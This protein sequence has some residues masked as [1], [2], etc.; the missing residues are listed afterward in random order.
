MSRNEW[1]TIAATWLFILYATASTHIL[2][3][4]L[5]GYINAAKPW[6]KRARKPGKTPALAR[7]QVKT[8][9]RRALAVFRFFT[10][11]TPFTHARLA[12]LHV[13]ALYEIRWHARPALAGVALGLSPLLLASLIIGDIDL[14]L[15]FRNVL[16]STITVGTVIYGGTLF[17]II[18]LASRK[19]RRLGANLTAIST[20]LHIATTCAAYARGNASAL[21]IVKLVDTVCRQIADFTATHEALVTPPL[22]TAVRQHTAAVRRELMEASAGLLREGPSALPRLVSLIH[23]M[24]QRITSDQWLA[25]LDLGDTS[26]LPNSQDS[27]GDVSESNKDAGIAMLTSLLASAALATATTMGLPLA[28]GFPAALIL[29]IG[30]TIWFG[31][32]RLRST[33]ENLLG[34]VRRSLTEAAQEPASLPNSQPGDANQN[35]RAAPDR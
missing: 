32:R 1:L 5:F 17:T 18:L 29:L 15:D 16:A 25:L 23:T 2:A 12:H 13:A 35:F 33:P 19:W 24:I 34:A 8:Y 7:R 3:R 20:C 26:S 9:T 22:D 4:H 27:A 31:S 30:P 14:E 21:T 10:S 6:E 11:Q 28:A